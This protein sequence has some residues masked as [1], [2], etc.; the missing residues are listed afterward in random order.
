MARKFYPRSSSQMPRRL[1][2][3]PFPRPPA[4]IPADA[5]IIAPH[6]GVGRE[7]GLPVRN[8][9]SIAKELLKKNG[10]GIA[11]PIHAS[12][13]LAASVIEVCGPNDASSIARHFRE[14][15]GAILRSNIDVEK[16]K[17]RGSP[18]ARQAAEITSRYREMLARQR[19]VDSDAAVASALTLELV[20][21]KKVFVY[22][23]FRGRQFAARHEE[24]ELIDRLAADESDFYLPLADAPLFSANREWVD[25]LCER[26]WEMIPPAGRSCGHTGQKLAAV[27]AGISTDDVDVKA[28]EY[29]DMEAEVRGVLA[30][31]KAAALAGVRPG[32]I[33]VVCRDIQAYAKTLISVAREYEMPIDIDSD[34]EIGD[35]DLGAFVSLVL[36]V[37]ERRSAEDLMFE[38]AKDR[39]GFQ[40]EPTLRLML[41]RLGPGL[42]DEQ[43]SVVYRTR[44][45]SFEEWKEIT[46]EA[47]KLNFEGECSCGDWADRLMRL[48][49]DWD[50]RGKDKLG[51]SS[52]DVNAFDNFFD[53]LEQIARERRADPLSAAEFA[54][55][56]TDVLTN[57]K[58]SLHT[59]R[60]GVRVL[61]PNDAVGSEFDQMFVIGMAEGVLPAPSADSAVIDFYERE[62]LREQ[63]IEFENAFE[64]P[65]WEASTFYFTLLAC[66]CEIAFS[67]PKVYGDSETIASSYFK[68]L[69]LAPRR[70]DEHFVSGVSESRRA[71]L[72]SDKKDQDPVAL[73]ARHQFAVEQRRESDA[74]AD[75]YDGV[76]GVPVRWNSWSASSLARIGSCPFKWF[77]NDV[78][79][80]S[81]PAEAETDLQPNIRGNLLHKTL[82]LAAKRTNGSPEPRNLMLDVLEEVFAE[83]EECHG[84]LTLVTNWRLKRTEHLHKLERA[85]VDDT[86]IDAGAVIIETEKPFEV[87]YCGLTLKGW[88]DRIDLCP[89]GSIV[90]VDYKHGSYLGKIKDESGALRVEIQLPI[91]SAVALP[92][93]YPGS[94]SYGGRF[95]H[96]SDP[97]ITRAREVDLENAILRI[98][99]LLESG[100][101]AVDPDLKKDAC[102]YC[103]FDSVCRVGPRVDLKREHL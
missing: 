84:P 6:S 100:R 17:R 12:R 74:P 4:S 13:T 76:I 73:H 14:I 36:N 30:G 19:L 94:P 35:T 91:Y 2:T 1:I 55:D 96:I 80:L 44:P 24:F 34:V 31:A 56:V 71:F 49:F 7:L 48:L 38:T 9:Q 45:D 23:Y 90:A 103:T 46:A 16:L 75:T 82:E 64:M 3:D 95:F 83:A 93:L 25:H 54:S 20:T 21:P 63:G 58:T 65:R 15:V 97:K 77:L 27:F 22:G 40:Y 10:F 51:K 87:E 92:A 86:F 68:R 102:N 37:L 50:L 99:T 98:K 66:R 85:I 79:R 89:D 47:N 81:E 32:H 28:T 67:Y 43:R 5:V 41:H 62:S 57:I 33:A 70:A 29:T 53:S 11:T 26:G 60:G 72:L 52:A 69:G 18:R 78:L 101:F 8:L 61:L 88:I 42:S 59:E 39:R